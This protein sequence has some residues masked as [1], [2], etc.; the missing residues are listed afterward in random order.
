MAFIYVGWTRIHS[1]YRSSL[2]GTKEGKDFVTSTSSQTNARGLEVIQLATRLIAYRN[3][4]VMKELLSQIQWE[5]RERTDVVKIVIGNDFLYDMNAP[6]I[7]T[8][9]LSFTIL[10]K[11]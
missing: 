6:R 1:Y 10:L 7:E 9:S 11:N 8:A 2:A 4:D 5:V 3:T